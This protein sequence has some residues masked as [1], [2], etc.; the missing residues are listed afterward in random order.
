MSEAFIGEVRM[1]GFGFAPLNWATCNGA[2]MSITQNTVLFSLLGTYYG[3]DGTRTFGL[4]NFQN[5][6]VVGAGTAAS[7]TQY[8]P[9]ET[10]GGTT[11]TLNVAETPPHTHAWHAAGG[12][13]VLADTNTPGPTTSLASATNC[14]PFVPTTA[15]PSLVKMDPLSLSSFGSATPV[16]HTNMM[17][18]VAMNF[19]IC[20]SGI[21]PTRP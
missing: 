12:R 15:T 17:P 16:P 19:C 4:P 2:I 1:M 8:E 6:V 3:G 18:T 11:V 5:S 9:G 13:G 14:T 10:G 7:G 21:F 20:L